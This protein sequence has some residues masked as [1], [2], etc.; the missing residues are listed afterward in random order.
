[1]VK[2]KFQATLRQQAKLW[3]TNFPHLLLMA[4][5][6][7]SP[8]YPRNINLS[9]GECLRSGAV[10][11]KFEGCFHTVASAFGQKLCSQCSYVYL[12]EPYW[13]N[14]FRR[15]AWQIKSSTDSS[16]L[17]PSSSSSNSGGTRLVRAIQALQTKIVGRIQEIRKNL[18]MKL[19][20]FLVGFYCATAFATVIGQTGDWDIL[21]AALAVVVVEGIGALMYRASFPLFNN[22]RSLITMFNYWKAG[23]SLGLF[24]DS[25]KY[26]FN[27]IMNYS[28]PFYFE[29][30]IFPF[31]F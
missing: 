2:Y 5:L 4:T 15:A 22:V 28:N 10:V 11:V 31:F 9:S 23:L 7:T 17:D 14:N 26:E 24:L 25:F 13:D 3:Y 1:M 12:A 18:P 21:S 6:M 27:D 16:G 20:F 8:S 29:M 30:D 19:L